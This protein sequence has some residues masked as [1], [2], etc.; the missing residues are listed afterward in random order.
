MAGHGLSR[1]FVRSYKVGGSRLRA[2]PRCLLSRIT[3]WAGVCAR[4]P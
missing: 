1:P 2:L 3:F 4:S